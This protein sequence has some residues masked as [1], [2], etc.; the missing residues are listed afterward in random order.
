MSAIFAQRLIGPLAS[1]ATCPRDVKELAYKGLMRPVL[2]Y[3]SSVWDLRSC[4]KGQLDL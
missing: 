2:E 1:L 3:G 4:R